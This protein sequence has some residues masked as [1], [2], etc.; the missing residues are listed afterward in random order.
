VLGAADLVD[1]VPSAH[2]EREAALARQKMRRVNADPCEQ[3]GRRNVWSRWITLNIGNHTGFVRR[4]RA[5]AIGWRGRGLR[6]QAKNFDAMPGYWRAA[7][8]VVADR[9]G[10]TAQCPGDGGDRK[11]LG[12]SEKLTKAAVSLFFGHLGTC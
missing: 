1:Y 8:Y 11:T 2:V 7:S 6:E 9:A 5:R 12:Q 10:T 3:L 4:R